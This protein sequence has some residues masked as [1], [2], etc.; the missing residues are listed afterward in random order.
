[1]KHLTTPSLSILIAASAF[2]QSAPAAATAWSQ[3]SNI[4][5]STDYVFRGVSQIA[6]SN[7][8]A[9]SGGTDIAHSSGFAVGAWF[10]NQNFNSN[11]DNDTL[12]ADLYAS[13]TFKVGSADLSAGVITYNYPGANAYNTIEG[14]L[15][16]ALSGV[17]LKYAYAFTDYF[18]V[19][20]SD[21]TS[22]LDLSYSRSFGDLGIGLH[23]G[24]TIGAGAQ[25]DYQDYKVSLSYPV[26]GYT[27][28]VAYTDANLSGVS[29]NSKVLDKGVTVFSLSKTF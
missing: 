23:Y 6:S 11:D 15:G 1:M 8:M 25:D 29:Y 3:T 4:A 2:A 10:S 20:T 19:A 9:F 24:W 12:E 18:G 14:N 13:Y 17:S 26:L 7:A 22:Y 27:A 21:G 28:T 5:L 16:V